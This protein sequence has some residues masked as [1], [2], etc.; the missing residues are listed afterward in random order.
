MGLRVHA[1]RGISPGAVAVLS[2]FALALAGLS[3]QGQVPEDLFSGVTTLIAT[4]S[5][6]PRVNVDG[7]ISP[8]EYDS[9]VTYRT[10]DSGISLSLLHDNES[11]FI[12]ITGPA[13][14]WAAVG[15]SSDNASTMGF[16]LIFRSDGGYAAQERL[17]TTVSEDMVFSVPA[18]E[19]AAV[20]DFE[21]MSGP[22]NDVT[23]EVEL[24][25]RSSIWSLGTGIIYPAVVA[26]NLTLST[27]PP[28]SLSGDSVHFVGAY[29]LRPDD[30][31]KD[32]NDLLNGKISPVPSIVVAVVLS[33][34]IV[35][36]FSEFVIR[37]RRA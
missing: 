32:V 14:S 12:G 25:L 22:G 18:P 6:H 4:Y 7:V 3:G 2:I 8:G 21:E 11:L 19:S 34:G 17:V 35:A 29:L 16:V 31:V 37:R 23:A 20:Q 10:P 30:S 27:G 26:T 5:P 24:S 13:W 15:F 28:S 1:A 33:V 36:I 9:N